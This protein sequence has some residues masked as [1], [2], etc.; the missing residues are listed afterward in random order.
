[1]L[2]YIYESI[3]DDVLIMCESVF[4]GGEWNNKN[5]SHYEVSVYKVITVIIPSICVSSLWAGATH[6]S[7][8]RHVNIDFVTSSMENNPTLK[9]K[10]PQT[11]PESTKARE[12]SKTSGAPDASTWPNN[13]HTL[14]RH[15]P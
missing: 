13:K 12:E 4:V 6:R 7:T 1:M 9:K 2:M 5:V 10:R 11:K 15:G 8:H 3:T 14:E